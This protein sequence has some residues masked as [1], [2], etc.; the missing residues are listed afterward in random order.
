MDARRQNN[1]RANQATPENHVARRTWLERRAL[2]ILSLS[3]QA[4]QTGTNMVHSR[5]QSIRRVA[6]RDAARDDKLLPLI[7]VPIPDVDDGARIAYSW[8]CRAMA[9]AP[10]LRPLHAR[11]LT[12]NH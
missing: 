4:S 5:H 7:A 3:F 1:A 10:R 8:Q 6:G 11:A 2:A 12:R 9:C